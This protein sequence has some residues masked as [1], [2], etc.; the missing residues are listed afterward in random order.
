MLRDLHEESRNDS[1]GAST[2]ARTRTAREAMAAAL[3]GESAPATG[4]RSTTIE[5]AGVR[6]RRCGYGLTV[7]SSGPQREKPESVV[8]SMGRCL[9]SVVLEY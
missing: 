5:Q 4:L 7:S 3:V 9:N 6:R 8:L 1:A 2:A